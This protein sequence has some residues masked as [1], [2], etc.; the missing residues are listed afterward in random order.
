MPKET[1]WFK[2][3]Y[4]ARGDRKMVAMRMKLGMKGV[5]LYWSIVEMLYEENGH[6][7][8]SECERIAFELQADYEDIKSLIFNFE[9]FK[10]DQK[11]FWSES[12]LNRLQVRKDKSIKASQSAHSRWENANALPSQSDSN[13]IRADK[14]RKEEIR[15][16][17]VCSAEKI[18]ELKNLALKTWKEKPIPDLFQVSI[19][20]E[21]FAK[22]YC[23]QKISAPV[24]LAKA[25]LNNFKPEKQINGSATNGKHSGN[26]KAQG[27]E[28]YAERLGRANKPATA[29]NGTK[30]TSK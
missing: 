6:L 3:D 25:W 29:T 7:M 15:I 8:L 21:N 5:G 16:D 26:F 2:H 9:L 17:N 12:V 27:Q 4:N 19:E 22:K 1:Y 24:R 23:G 20:S 14:K 18:S 30:P 13:A 11:K 28:L 10:K